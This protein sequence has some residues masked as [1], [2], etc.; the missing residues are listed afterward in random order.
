MS[1]STSV[2]FQRCAALNASLFIPVSIQ[3]SISYPLSTHLVGWRKLR[4]P[5]PDLS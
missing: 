2:T 5:R 1:A 4:L 3:L